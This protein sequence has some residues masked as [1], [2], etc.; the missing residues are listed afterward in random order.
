MIIVASKVSCHCGI[1]IVFDV[2]HMT[3]ESVY[4][5]IFGLTHIFGVAPVAFKAIY[6]V[7]ALACALGHCV[8]IFVIVW[9]FYFP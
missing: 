5:S 7:V 9:V 2:K 8:I 4:D 1:E 3:L 6:Q